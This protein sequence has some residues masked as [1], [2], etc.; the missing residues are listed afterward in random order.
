MMNT[1]AAELSRR[2]RKVMP[3]PS[4]EG[5]MG[6]AA[7]RACGRASGTA[8]EAVLRRRPRRAI[9]PT[10]GA[11]IGAATTANGVGSTAWMIAGT[12]E[13]GGGSRT[14]REQI[15]DHAVS[16]HPDVRMLFR[17]HDRPREVG[18]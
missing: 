5:A 15:A 14:D 1:A 18:D 13:D 9:P 8:G 17:D 7:V 12:R 4:S 2:A 10:S 16:G 6:R 3:S 11:A